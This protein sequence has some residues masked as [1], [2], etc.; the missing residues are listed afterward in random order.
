MKRLRLFI[1]VVV[2]LLVLF[3]VGCSGGGDRPLNVTL[4]D[5]FQEFL[6]DVDAA[7]DKYHDKNI[8]VSGQVDFVENAHLVWQKPYINMTQPGAPILSPWV[9]C[10]L[11]DEALSKDI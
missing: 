3:A 6:D 10:L 4:E 9:V 11:S 8:L 1:P 2:L 5:L 7:S